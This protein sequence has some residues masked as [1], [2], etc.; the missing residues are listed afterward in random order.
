MRLIHTK[1]LAIGCVGGIV[2][3]GPPLYLVMR[4]FI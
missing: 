4:P 1:A 3:I 2:L